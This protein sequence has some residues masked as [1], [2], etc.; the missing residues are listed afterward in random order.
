LPIQG[1]Q[2][3]D[4]R[5]QIRFRASDQL[6]APGAVWHYYQS[7]AQETQGT[8]V[9][10]RVIIKDVSASQPGGVCL[11]FFV[12][13]AT[14]NGC[15]IAVDSQ[16]LGFIP[17]YFVELMPNLN[18]FDTLLIC[19]SGVNFQELMPRAAWLLEQSC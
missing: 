7:N 10:Y 6:P 3:A 18:V 19:E 2:L 13:V 16:Y 12:P 1:G 9:Y 11:H 4:N 15:G 14:I 5:Q 8:F 17:Q